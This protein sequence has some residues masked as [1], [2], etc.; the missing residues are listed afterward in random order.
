MALFGPNAVCHGDE[1]GEPVWP[2]AKMEAA[3]AEAYC[4]TAAAYRG[5]I[6]G[7]R[8]RAELYE[9]ATRFASDLGPRQE[10]TPSALCR[11]L[12]GFDSLREIGVK[13]DQLKAGL[14]RQGIVFQEDDP[15]QFEVSG[16][17]ST[18][19][20]IVD[21]FDLEGKVL[22]VESGARIAPGD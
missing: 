4:G 10:P 11:S 15:L 22:H 13:F 17:D 5:E 3:L 19:E 6:P 2:A 7:D 16:V 8:E 20:L 14:T 9:T 21:Y 18:I 12:V 1:A